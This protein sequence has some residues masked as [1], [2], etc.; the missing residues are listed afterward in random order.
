MKTKE[1]VK[2]NIYRIR[3]RKVMLD[4]DLASLYGIDKRP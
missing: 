1:L 3:G 2:N 4:I